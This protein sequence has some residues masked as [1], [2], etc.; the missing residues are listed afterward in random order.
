MDYGDEI[1]YDDDPDLDMVAVH[2]MLMSWSLDKSLG[3]DDEWEVVEIN[4]EKIK[5]KMGLE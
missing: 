5:D 3:K 1:D 4:V 2:A